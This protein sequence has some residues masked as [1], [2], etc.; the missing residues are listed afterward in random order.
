MSYQILLVEDDKAIREAV[1]DYLEAKE[2]SVTAVENSDLAQEALWTQNFDLLLLDIMLPG[3]DGFSLCREVRQH[4]DVPIMFLTARILVEDKIHGYSLGCDDYLVKPFSLAELHVRILALIKRSKGMVLNQVLTAGSISLDP[5]AH[6][7][8]VDGEWVP[9]TKKE[10]A[11]LKVLM[12]RKNQTFSRDRLLHLVWGG[13]F[14]GSDRVVDNHI[15]K[16]RK[17]LGKASKSIH[18][19][20]GVGYRLEDKL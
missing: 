4:S 6:L 14:D 5:T 11:L 8:T 9:L 18:T 3:P 17:S 1:Q 12:E 2:L 15:R 16:L 19:V 20:I 13:D 10:Y 7:V